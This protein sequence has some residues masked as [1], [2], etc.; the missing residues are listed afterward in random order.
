MDAFAIKQ[1]AVNLLLAV[2]LWG[3][4]PHAMSGEIR[5]AV[6]SNFSLAMKALDEIFV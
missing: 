2:A 1:L 5:V 3:S 4:G 6:A